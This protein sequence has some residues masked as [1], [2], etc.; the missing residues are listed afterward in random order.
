MIDSQ[1]C[2]AYN[3]ISLLVLVDKKRKMSNCS[4]R[5]VNCFENVRKVIVRF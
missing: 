3:V 2:L 4:R 1:T 5:N